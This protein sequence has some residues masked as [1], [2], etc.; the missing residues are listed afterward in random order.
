M[1]FL[2]RPKLLIIERE[3]SMY[4]KKPTNF[5]SPNLNSLQE[6]VID[7]RTKIYIDLNEDPEK[8]RNRYLSR[9]KFKRLY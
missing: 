7:K 9:L 4:E 8:A 5:K 2:K 6:V 1:L 3:Y